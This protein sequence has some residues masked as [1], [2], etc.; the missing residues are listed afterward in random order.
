MKAKNKILIVD[1]EPVNVKVLQRKLEKAG[2]EVRMATNGF[3]CLD[4]VEE[5][6]P[7]IILLDIMM[8][9]MDGV[10][11]CR[12]LKQNPKTE[13]IPVIFV[14]AK[15][16]RHD[17]ISGLETGAI[18]YITKPIDMEETLA[19]VR[20]HL[21]LETMHEENIELQQRLGEARRTA[22][23][24]SMTQGIA[25]NLNNLLGVV[26]GYL[27]L[28]KLRM[29]QPEKL[30]KGI[31]SMEKAVKR[32]VNLVRQLSSMVT[33]EPVARIKADP[34]ECVANVVNRATR[35]SEGRVQTVSIENNLPEDFQTF[36][37]LETIETCVEHLIRNGIESYPE[38][39]P[40]EDRPIRVS[41]N[42]LEEDGENEVE[43]RV[44]DR[45][46]GIHPSVRDN[47]FDPFIS[48]K[49]SV[50][51]GFGLT[52]VKHSIS[53]IGGGVTIGANPS[54]QGTSAVL[55][56]PVETE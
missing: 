55:R 4:R 56:I 6:R 9:D 15:M 19:R 46:E 52:V 32:M 14:T 53:H 7:D 49:N 39:T 37:S 54:G 27:D 45:G 26:V 21:R 20:T 40:A 44:S 25:H 48:T 8:P 13:T 16:D 2:Y 38:G 42:L 3:E 47:L 11:T 5:S 23:I 1:D 36:T 10:E 18:D 41:L 31:A 35:Q 22:A 12:R 50:G 34:A 30:E 24:G 33:D 28:L 43:I 17:K 29:N 51:R